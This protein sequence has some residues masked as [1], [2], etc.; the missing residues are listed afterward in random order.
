MGNI[1]KRKVVQYKATMMDQLVKIT[2]PI[3]K[4]SFP[5]VKSVGRK[6]F[7]VNMDDFM[8]HYK[9]SKGDVIG[10]GD[11]II[12]NI[13][14]EHDRLA[15]ETR[16]SM[17][18]TP[19]DILLL[20]QRF[21]YIPK[22]NALLCNKIPIDDADLLAGGLT[23]GKL[24]EV[25]CGVADKT[26]NITLTPLSDVFGNAI[27]YLQ[28]MRERGIFR[29]SP[30]GVAKFSKFRFNIERL[31]RNIETVKKR[32]ADYKI[33]LNAINKTADQ[34]AETFK[35]KF[36]SMGM[37]IGAAKKMLREPKEINSLITRI[38]KMI[39]AEKKTGRK[40][41]VEFRV[42]PLLNLKSKLYSHLTNVSMTE[43]YYEVIN[44]REKALNLLKVN[45]DLHQKGELPRS[46]LSKIIKIP[47][48]MNDEEL[49]MRVSKLLEKI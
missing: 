11:E 2:M 33:R 3:P 34:L 30:E 7:N 48:K 41:R 26:I 20:D 39:D 18:N 8:D 22:N 36:Q 29:I 46:E 38:S 17:Q 49:K 12:A 21:Q 43:N 24:K 47:D 1:M 4:L 16:E 14:A 42:S 25:L 6:A 45:L 15:N 32:K 13:R 31:E 19:I 40:S 35:D 5:F 23:G 10:K 37:K 9:I 28:K 27:K 44:N